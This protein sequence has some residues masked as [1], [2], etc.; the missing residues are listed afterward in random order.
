MEVTLTEINFG[1]SF[2][3]CCLIYHTGADSKPLLRVLLVVLLLL[4]LM[5]LRFIMISSGQ[6]AGMGGRGQDERVGLVERQ[7]A[8]AIVVR[9]CL[10]WQGSA[11]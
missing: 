10:T 9:P 11:Q 7:E 3:N 4:L 1:N 5:G 2:S 6:A 8:L